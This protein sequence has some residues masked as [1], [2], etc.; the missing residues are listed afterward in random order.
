MNL[1]LRTLTA[2]TAALL[3]ALAL[4]ACG[5]TSDSPSSSPASAGVGGMTG[6]SSTATP[7]ATGAPA[8]G[9]HNEADVT[10]ATDMVPHHAQAVTMADM[11]LTRGTSAEVKTLAGA[12]KAAQDPE[13]ST[14]TGWLAGWG[15][16]VPEIGGHDMAGMGGGSMDGMMTDREMSDLGR[17]TGPAFDRMWLEMMT[18]H[19]KGAVAMSTTELTAGENTEAK[20]LARSI[21][22]GQTAELATM[23]TLLATLPAA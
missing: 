19:H 14:M 20:T 9:P 1:T 22:T 8:A 6:M 10:F 5:S 4:A 17:A 16:P 7:G 13:I 21:I 23:A 11:A 3:A 2:P 18:T 12:I 15:A